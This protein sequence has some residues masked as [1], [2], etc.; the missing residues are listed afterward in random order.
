MTLCDHPLRYGGTCTLD[1][2]HRGHHS[3]VTYQCDGCG[4]VRRGQPYAWARDGEYEHGLAFCFMCAAP[5]IVGV[6]Q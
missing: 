4:K 3:G 1:K 6:P 2:D 5:Q